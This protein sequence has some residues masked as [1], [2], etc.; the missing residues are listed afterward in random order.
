M[1]RCLRGRPELGAKFFLETFE[2]CALR[3]DRLVFI[4][5]CEYRDWCAKPPTLP[6]FGA[7]EAGARVWSLATSSLLSCSRFW[8]GLHWFVQQFEAD[9]EQENHGFELRGLTFELSRTR[10]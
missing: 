1:A 4:V 2:A 10:R 6:M 3:A 9:S 8:M 5:S 7:G